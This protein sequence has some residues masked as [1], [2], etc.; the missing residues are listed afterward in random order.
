LLKQFLFSLSLLVLPLTASANW[1]VG[2]GYANLSAEDDGDDLSLGAI[3]GSVAYEFPQADSQFSIMPELRVG[4]GVSD[5]HIDSIT[6]EVNSFIT[7]SVRGQY[8]YDNGV[9][10]Y[11]MPSYANLD[12]KASI[13]G[14][15]ISDDEWELG[16]GGGVGKKLNTNI[17]VE[18]S[19]ES[20]DDTD[21]FTVGF[22]YAF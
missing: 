7:L 8:N 6:V 3:Y 16:F 12:S 5:D 21:A 11:V 19:F 20:Y 2:A 22:K 10:L 13:Q 1:L 4:T 9:Y 15:S 17:S 18:V 14:R